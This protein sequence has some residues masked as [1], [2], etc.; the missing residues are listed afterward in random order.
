MLIKM[1]SLKTE[2]IKHKALT[3]YY[4]SVEVALINPLS[5][6]SQNT[7]QK[8]VQKKLILLCRRL[9]SILVAY[10]LNRLPVHY[11]KSDMGGAAVVLGVGK[12]SQA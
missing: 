3:L 9:L 8:S 10:P 11:M 4:L 7:T 6:S 5:A 12:I 1:Y 2:T